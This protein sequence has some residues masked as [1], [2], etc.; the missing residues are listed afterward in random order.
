MHF[1]K[2]LIVV[3]LMQRPT[4][5]D[6]TRLEKKMILVQVAVTKANYKSIKKIFLN[7]TL[8]CTSLQN[9]ATAKT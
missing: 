5:E 1:I 7:N 6:E 2:P 3:N 9:T 4:F 8:L